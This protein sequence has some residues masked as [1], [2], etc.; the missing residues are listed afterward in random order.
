MCFVPALCS[1]GCYRVG[2]VGVEVG[3]GKYD[4]AKQAVGRSRLG[5]ELTIE[6]AGSVEN[7]VIVVTGFH[8]N[9]PSGVPVPKW[10]RSKLPKARAEL[11]RFASDVAEAGAPQLQSKL[12][13]PDLSVAC[14][15]VGV[16]GRLAADDVESNSVAADEL[17]FEWALQSGDW[18]WKEMVSIRRK[19]VRSRPV[20]LPR[21]AV[22]HQR[23]AA[24]AAES[25]QVISK[26]Y[27]AAVSCTYTLESHVAR[28]FQPLCSPVC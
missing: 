18:G 6:G 3:P 10:A 13:V 5:F 9:R 26:E 2:Y 21:C 16:S 24:A 11:D 14:R 20:P 23:L 7:E 19:D 22:T 25:A 8:L 15:Y 1:D 12:D 27:G 28:A 17:E 4:L